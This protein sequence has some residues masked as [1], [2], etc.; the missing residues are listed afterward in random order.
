MVAMIRS[1]SS[2]VFPSSSVSV[3]VVLI[4]V[5]VGAALPEIDEALAKLQPLRISVMSSSC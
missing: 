1:V 5:T 2:S 4:A 3:K